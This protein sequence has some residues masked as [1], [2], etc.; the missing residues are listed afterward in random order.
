VI[1]DSTKRF[2]G[3][4]SINLGHGLAHEAEVKAI[5]FSLLFCQ[6]FS[7]TNVIIESDSTTTVGWVNST[8]N[9]PWKLRNELNHIDYLLQVVSALE[10]KHIYRE[11]NIVPD[12]LANIGCNRESPLWELVEGI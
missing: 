10:V 12:Y 6:Q 4:F 2:R 11:L 9:R 8:T 3:F 1:R 5:L 7:I